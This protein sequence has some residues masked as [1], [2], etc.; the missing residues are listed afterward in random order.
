MITHGSPKKRGRVLFGGIVPYGERW[1]TEQI[2]QPILR[3]QG[4]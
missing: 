2:G 1:R 3:H 4:H